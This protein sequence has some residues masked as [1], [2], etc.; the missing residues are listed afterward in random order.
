MRHIR[1]EQAPRNFASISLLFPEAN[2]VLRIRSVLLAAVAVIPFSLAAQNTSMR[3]PIIGIAKVSVYAT[4]MKKSKQFYG[5]F[6]GFP[7]IASASASAPMEFRV[8]SK[9][10]D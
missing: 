2:S 6:L 8:S 10:I 7:Q 5:T 9:Q 1:A 4:D 3:P